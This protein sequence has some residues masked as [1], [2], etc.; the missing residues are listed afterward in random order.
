MQ[1]RKDE[2]LF[3]YHP[4]AYLERKRNVVRG[5]K[6]RTKILKV[7]AMTM[8]TAMRKS[9][10]VREKENEFTIKTVSESAAMSYPSSFHHLRLLEEERIVKREGKRPYK[11]IITGKGQRSLNELDLEL[12]NK[13]LEVL[14][15]K[16][17]YQKV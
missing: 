9:E 1:K 8:E 10:E 11:W 6:A 5:L 12:E 17:L 4:N 2:H 7:L 15:Q 3:K 13:K 14:N 16:V